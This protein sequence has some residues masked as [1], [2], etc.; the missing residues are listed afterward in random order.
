[1]RIY[2]LN[3]E[4]VKNYHSVRYVGGQTETIE[5][6]LSYFL[7]LQVIDKEHSQTLRKCR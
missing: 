4:C 6:Y 3:M 7:V 1:M 5:Y 2:I